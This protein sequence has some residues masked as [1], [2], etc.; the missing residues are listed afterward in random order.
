MDYALARRG[1]TAQARALLADLERLAD[2][3]YVPPTKVATGWLGLEQR[4]QAFQWLGRALDV[5]DDR[6]VYLVV[7]VHFLELH[8]DPDFRAYA[9]RVGLLEVLQVRNLL[10]RRSLPRSP[11]LARMR[12]TMGAGSRNEA[13]GAEILL[14][15]WTLAENREP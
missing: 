2:E 14:R 8:E 6:L 12:R 13:P 1:A 15:S 7:D 5:H 3:Q 4:D 10:A 9:D 11:T